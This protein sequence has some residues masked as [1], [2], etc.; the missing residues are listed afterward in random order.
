[1]NQQ[2]ALENAGAGTPQKDCTDPSKWVK[3]LDTCEEERSIDVMK[4]VCDEILSNTRNV[5]NWANE[6]VGS[7]TKITRT[8]F[9]KAVETDNVRWCKY[10][11]NTL[12]QIFS[13]K[14]V[15]EAVPQH[16][17]QTLIC[18]LMD[19]MLDERTPTMKDGSNMIKALNLLM[20]RILDNCKKNYTFAVLLQLLRPRSNTLSKNCD[21][22]VRCL[23]R[24]SK[25]LITDVQ[26]L[27]LDMLFEEIQ[28]F[29]VAAVPSN[30]K[31]SSSSEATALRAVKTLVNE[32][33]RIK[34]ASVRDHLTRI[35]L[36]ADKENNPILIQYIDLMLDNAN[37]HSVA[38]T[39]HQAVS[40][41][42]SQAEDAVNSMRVPLQSKQVSEP[43]VHVDGAAATKNY[44]SR[45]QTL[46]SRYGFKPGTT[47]VS[48]AESAKDEEVEESNSEDLSN[49][50]KDRL[51]YLQD[52]Y[53]FA[54]VEGVDDAKSSVGSAG[55]SLDVQGL[56]DRVKD[57]SASMGTVSMGSSPSKA[58][59]KPATPVVATTATSAAAAPASVAELRARL[60]RV[61]GLQT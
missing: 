24:M 55:G 35:P 58:A 47:E 53:G 34:G 43:S 14:T 40:H 7:L 20:L 56:K 25:S 54:K 26:S 30:N 16:I 39:K 4:V 41:E 28:N 15:A 61:K 52:R 49:K 38:S 45:L 10:V 21:L 18:E 32:M 60:N 22:I 12:M 57:L 3:I 31:D 36:S 19:R 59:V 51:K 11:L 23:L 13:R 27:N 9:L 29:F 44:M 33:V 37:T 50:Y 17:L 8:A 48:V 5:T 6:L 1:M 42:D 2:K 46:Q